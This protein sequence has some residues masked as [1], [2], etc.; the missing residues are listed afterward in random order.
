MKYWVVAYD[1]PNDRRR[2]KLANVLEDFG[3]RVQESVFEVMLFGTE[4][5]ELK[6]RILD[7]ID[8]SED[9]VRLY[10]LCRVCSEKVI[11][12]GNASEEAFEEKEVIIA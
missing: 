10:P 2:V 11:D 12:L 6:Y 5:D 1:I 7:V 9:K 4:L 8:V 3:D